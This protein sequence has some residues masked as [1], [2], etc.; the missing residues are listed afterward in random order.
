[1]TTHALFEAREDKTAQRGL[2]RSTTEAVTEAPP[3]FFLQRTHARTTQERTHTAKGNRSLQGL[4]FVVKDV[5]DVAGT[6]T[7]SGS[8]LY[9]RAPYAVRDAEAVR[10]LSAAGGICLGKTTMS[11]LAYSG[12]G[13]NER[14]GTPT[15]QRNGI[16]YLVGGSSSGAAAAVHYGAAPL[17]L[18]S[19][20]SGS[21]RIP[22]AWAGVFGFRPSLGR[23]P[24]TGMVALAP[25]LD[26]A[27][28]IASSLTHIETAD[29]V[30]AGESQTMSDD[31][32]PRF[33]APD[34]EYLATCDPAVL[35]QFHAELTHLR[36]EGHRIVQRRFE[37]LHIARSLHRLHV[38]IVESE[39]FSIYGS[40]LDSPGLLS[41]PV[42]RRLEHARVRLCE[43]SSDGLYRA[44]ATL[45]TQF[46]KEL[47]GAILLS[48]PVE[49][50]APS[51]TEV[52][53]S[54]E[55]HDE[56]NRRALT[57]TM[58]LSYLDAPSLVIPGRD[59]ATEPPSSI[60][61]SGSSGQDAKVLHAARLLAHT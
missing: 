47:T 61:L 11:E 30:L 35:E 53:T 31:D 57:L 6:R 8:Q 19:D 48:P 59:D 25:T 51:Y 32:R 16:D 38:P 42:Q 29:R 14:F 5:F 39:A 55:A 45:R 49:I 1:M 46:S 15:I 40:H 41:Q 3:E 23:Y 33:V 54:T 12:L 60:Q 4:A 27:A 52:Q 10:R 56:L 37:A 2:A 44:M 13:F 34:D 43:H 28:V 36:S 20:T 26:T 50:H 9:D 22:A 21:A 58:L 7:T 18:A 24:G 17:A